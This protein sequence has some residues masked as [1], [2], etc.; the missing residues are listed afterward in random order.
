MR[1]VEKLGHVAL[2]LWA[3]FA[4]ASQWNTW[5]IDASALYFSAYFYDLGQ[6]ALVYS[7]EPEFFMQVPPA[8]WV[9]LAKLQGGNVG[10]FSPYVYPPLWAALLAP[11]AK[12]L[13]AIGFFNLLTVLNVGSVVI[14]V[15][16]SYLLLSPKKI[17]FTLWSLVSIGLIQFSW[18]GI[19]AIEI[20]QPQVF[21][22][23]LILVSFWA[24]QSGRA[25]LAGA[26]LGVAA[27]IKIAPGYLVVIFIMERRWRALAMFF[28]V[29]AAFASLSLLLAGPDLHRE[30]WLRL[31]DL[32]SK[33]LVARINLTFESVLMQIQ[34]GLMG[35]PGW[36]FNQPQFLDKPDWVFWVNKAALLAGLGVVY[37]S[38]RHLPSG[39]RIWFRLQLVFLI[40]LITS[41][42]AWAHYLVL[43]ILLLPGLLTVA[44]A[45]LASL[46]LFGFLAIFS[47][48]LYWVLFPLSYRGNA[49]LFGGF[50]AVIVLLAALIWLAIQQSRRIKG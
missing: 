33:V 27:A 7:P 1:L 34:N 26:V 10:G 3:A 21:V 50:F 45:R 17:G 13:T 31:Q 16:V 32:N 5:S 19:L 23:M 14:G 15:N 4:V 40:T 24:L 29:G 35:A 8:E 22:T 42:L 37:F 25:R 20:G 46:L 47:T 36:V 30:F 49:M 28:A 6:G 48:E 2:F 41:P 18:I 44:N 9:A 39:R 38:T 43:T 11:I 12:N